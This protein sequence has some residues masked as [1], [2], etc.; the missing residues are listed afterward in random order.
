FFISLSSLNFPLLNYSFVI[1]SLCDIIQISYT[2]IKYINIH[3][4][5]SRVFM[6]I[7]LL[8]YFIAVANHQNISAAAKY[9]HIS[10]PSLSR[11]LSDLE[12]EL[13]TA[14]FTGETEKLH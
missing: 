10:H 8:R 9:L 6:E 2:Y 7:R 12:T 3:I 13:G 4:E 5:H 11:Q 1:T 14:L